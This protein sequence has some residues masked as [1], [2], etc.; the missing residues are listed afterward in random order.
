MVSCKLMSL[1]LFVFVFLS[2]TAIVADIILVVSYR[3]DCYVFVPI[4]VIVNVID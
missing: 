2:I 1:M 3:H 4:V